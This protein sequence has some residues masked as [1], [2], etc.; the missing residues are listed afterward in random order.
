MRDNSTDKDRPQFE[1]LTRLEN[2]HRR[3]LE[4]EERYKRDKGEARAEL[5]K[6][7]RDL[8]AIERAPDCFAA[9]TWAASN[10]SAPKNDL[11]R[12]LFGK[13]HQE[14]HLRKLMAGP[15]RACEECGQQVLAGHRFEE[16]F[17]IAKIA[18]LGFAPSG[19]RRAMKRNCDGKQNV[20][21]EIG[22]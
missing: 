8:V 10:T 6:A 20:P 21:H 22:A 2:A 19:A 18:P 12:V 4:V 5:E 15:H 3:L 7:A 11:A 13:E 14:Y 9:V 17:F 16:S 1:Q